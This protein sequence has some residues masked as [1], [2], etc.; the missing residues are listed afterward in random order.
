MS[1]W[2]CGTLGGIGTTLSVTTVGLG[3]DCAGSSVFLSV[4]SISVHSCLQLQGRG[5]REVLWDSAL[6]PHLGMH[7]EYIPREERC[8]LG[9]LEPLIPTPLIT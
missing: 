2:S 3:G 7:S 8:H 6:L 4:R 1:I 5:L 9:D